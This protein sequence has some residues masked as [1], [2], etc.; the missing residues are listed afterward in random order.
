MTLRTPRAKQPEAPVAINRAHP[1]AVNLIGAW[2]PGS[3]RNLVGSSELFVPTALIGTRQS[4]AGRF[5][6]VLATESNIIN[7][8]AL[9]LA[10][11]IVTGTA[12]SQSAV[13]GRGVNNDE[14]GF[15]ATHADS[16]Y[17]GA[18]YTG[19]GY[20]IIGKPAGGALA[21]DTRYDFGAR[22][23]G[24]NGAVFSNGVLVASSS[25]LGTPGASST[26]LKFGQ[27]S[28]SGDTWTVAP[29]LLYL[30]I[31]A[32]AIPDSTFAKIAANP[33]QVFTPLPRRVLVPVAAVGGGGFV[34][35]RTLHSTGTRIGSRAM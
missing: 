20:T 19:S 5:A 12:T 35:R 2:A 13:F 6:G 31:W 32:G 34:S 23:S 27:Q 7:G 26:S 33:W 21:N 3:R 25:S 14:W 29:A 8:T 4:R 24:A 16:T 30:F 1:L 17:A 22:F 15:H 18:F 9:S 11:G 28:A 10:F